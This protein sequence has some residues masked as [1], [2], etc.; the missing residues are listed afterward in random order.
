VA[1][2][3]KRLKWACWSVCLPAACSCQRF[4]LSRPGQAPA[5]FLARS[6][7]VAADFSP[8]LGVRAQRAPSRARTRPCS[9]KKRPPFAAALSFLKP[10]FSPPLCPC[11]A[12]SELLMWVLGASSATRAFQCA[13]QP[14]A[15]ARDA[16]KLLPGP[17]CAV[18]C[19]RPCAENVLVTILIGCYVSFRALH[20]A[21]VTSRVLRGPFLCRTA[22]PSRASRRKEPP[23]NQGQ[24]LGS[25]GVLGL[26]WCMR[27]AAAARRAAWTWTT[28]PWKTQAL[29]QQLTTGQPR[30]GSQAALALTHLKRHLHG[31]AQLQ[32][33]LGQGTLIIDL[34]SPEGHW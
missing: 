15:S 27:G 4:P 16:R 12:C 17:L 11:E 7:C 3:C 29:G 5:Q 32:K 30:P 28:P 13:P 10:R 9:S 21:C 31:Q 14:G 22:L 20:A 8:C 1:T 25:W 23:L 2:T 18:R 34:A 24:G 26:R 33:Q 6:G 19:G